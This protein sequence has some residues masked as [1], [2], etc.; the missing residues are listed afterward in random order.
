M[1]TPQK[2]KNQHMASMR[3]I[4]EYISAFVKLFLFPTLDNNCL[5]L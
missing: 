3:Y 1:N 2:Y 4:I 5:L